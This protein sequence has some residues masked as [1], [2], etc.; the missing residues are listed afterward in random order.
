MCFTTAQGA[1]SGQIQVSSPLPA[2]PVPPRSS[3]G[4]QG[5]C[6]KGRHTPLTLPPSV[7][8]A[9]KSLSG[10]QLTSLFVD[11]VL[12]QPKGVEGSLAGVW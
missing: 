8:T 11:S 10:P 4:A 6:G 3:Q 12:L 9:L 5:A 2:E 7:M 1:R